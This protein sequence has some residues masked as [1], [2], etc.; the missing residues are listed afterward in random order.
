MLDLGYRNWRSDTAAGG[1][2]PRLEVGYRVCKSDNGAVPRI[3]Q[4]EVGYRSCISDNLVG[5]IKLVI[6]GNKA[7]FYLI[8][9]TCAP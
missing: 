3:P 6:R 9:V 7:M 2:I 1:R 4:L 8:I 5:R